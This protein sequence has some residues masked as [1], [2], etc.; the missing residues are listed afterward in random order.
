MEMKMETE[1]ALFTA[2]KSVVA[3]KPVQPKTI[4][5]CGWCPDARERTMTYK[6]Q[7]VVV[8]HGM[9]EPCSVKF[10]NGGR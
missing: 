9:C 3:V 4:S 8:S 6:R 5:I 2:M 1:V 10:K 7:G